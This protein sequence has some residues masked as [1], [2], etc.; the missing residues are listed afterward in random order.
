MLKPETTKVIQST[1]P[2]LQQHGESLTS[3]FYQRMFE[4][5]PEVKPFFNQAHQERGTQQR[6]LAGAICAYA[7]H[8]NSPEKLNDAVELIA[9]KHASLGI[10]PEHYPI[11][12]KNLIAAIRE[13]LGD[14]AT[15]E[16]VAAWSDAYGVLADIF[17][18]REKEIYQ[19]HRD[20][21]GWQGFKD[22]EVRKREAINDIITSFYLAPVDGTRLP[23]HSAGQ[24]ITVKWPTNDG[25]TTL[26]NYSLSNRP[27]KEHYRIS[28]KRERSGNPVIP[29]G[30]VSN[31]LHD[32]IK[33]GDIIKI[34]PPCGEFTLRDLPAENQDPVVFIAGGIGITPL[35]SMLHTVLE[36][37]GKTPVTLI[38]AT[39]NGNTQAFEEEIIALSQAHEQLTWHTCF[40]EPNDEDRKN[41]RF[42]SEGLIDED[43]INTLL[44]APENTHVYLCGPEPM[45]KHCYN[46]LRYSNVPLD[47]I[48]TEFFGP[49]SNINSDNT[50]I[51]S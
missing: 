48:H 3:L 24:Y 36:E 39:V 37:D 38:Q 9:Q 35:L 11:V 18:N 2:I 41:K 30:I 8:I 34:A 26:R 7:E 17:I 51:N 10:K 14:A 22:F 19:Q 32:N 16:I 44:P 42:D 29:D 5:N 21:F 49:A 23:P 31:A 46:L 25:N 45:L 47:Q 4:N 6:A 33:Q 13:L 12:G 20:E 43:I 27:G 40:S 28:I 1:L 15:E 50:V